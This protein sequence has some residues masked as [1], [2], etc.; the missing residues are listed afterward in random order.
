M[1]VPDCDSSIHAGTGEN[2]LLR[3]GDG[4]FAQTAHSLTMGTR[5]LSEN[6]AGAISDGVDDNGSIA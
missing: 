3:C 4:A 5:D 1:Q 6:G 2:L